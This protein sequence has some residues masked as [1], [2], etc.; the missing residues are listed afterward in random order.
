MW[1]GDITICFIW[2]TNSGDALHRWFT[3]D[4]NGEDKAGTR[5]D[6]GKIVITSMSISVPIVSYEASY[7]LEFRGKYIK[8]S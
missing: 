7:E 1:E 8:K 5:P 3:K 4:E 6:E 2:S